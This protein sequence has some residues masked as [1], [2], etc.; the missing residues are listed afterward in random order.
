MT[1]LADPVETGQMVREGNFERDLSDEWTGGFV[2]CRTEDKGSRFPTIRMINK[3]HTQS[4]FP[5][6][7]YRH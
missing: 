5:K 7:T 4:E 1:E 2:E 3:C 6:S